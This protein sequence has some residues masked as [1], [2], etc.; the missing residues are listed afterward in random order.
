M[1]WQAP[2]TLGTEAELD[3]QV[4]S[5]L[6]MKAD[7]GIRPLIRGSPLTWALVNNIQY[8]R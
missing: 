8:E 4:H 3:A 1:A 5:K 6:L 2:L 7:L